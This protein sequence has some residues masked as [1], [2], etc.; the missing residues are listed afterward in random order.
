MKSLMVVLTIVALLAFIVGLLF[1]KRP[2]RMYLLFMLY[3]FPVIDLKLTPAAW[4]WGGLSIFEGL[5]YIIL[6]VRYKDFLTIFKVNRFYFFAFVT[7]MVLLILGSL[8]S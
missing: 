2:A 7:L 4:G 3:A 5:S 6:C 1:G 8:T